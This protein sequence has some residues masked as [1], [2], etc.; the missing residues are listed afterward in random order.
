MAQY[1]YFRNTLLPMKFSD[2][3]QHFLLH[4]TGILQNTYS[5]KAY[6]LLHFEHKNCATI[7]IKIHSESYFPSASSSL[8]K[9]D[10][11]FDVNFMF[12]M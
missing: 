2:I 10:N 6:V 11:D 3:L 1:F 12:K 9:F 5:M 4:S 8:Q 7:I